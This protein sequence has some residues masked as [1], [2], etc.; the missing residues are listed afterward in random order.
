MATSIVTMSTYVPPLPTV[1]DHFLLPTNYHV[2][3]PT[4]AFLLSSYCAPVALLPIPPFCPHQLS[5]H[6]FL[7]ATTACLMSTYCSLLFLTLTH[8]S[9]RVA[10]SPSGS[11]K[12]TLLNVLTGRLKNESV[13]HSQAS[14]APIDKHVVMN[15]LTQPS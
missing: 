10:T 14:V 12:T 4:T 7:F 6:A 3:T 5:C 13:T 15:L 8:I 11:G 2:P 9:N 1:L